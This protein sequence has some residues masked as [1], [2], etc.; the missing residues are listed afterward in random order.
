MNNRALLATR[1][2]LEACRAGR[3]GEI[4]KP[5]AWVARQSKTDAAPSK[6]GRK[7]IRWD[8]ASVVKADERPAETGLVAARKSLNR[9]LEERIHDNGLA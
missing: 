6:R 9:E 1:I 4:T 8:F 5:R 3:F 7:M 2:N